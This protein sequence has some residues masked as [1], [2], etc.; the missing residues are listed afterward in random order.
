MDFR[1]DQV[2][3]RF[4][5]VS[6]A[7]LQA[8]PLGAVDHLYAELGDDLTTETR[9]QMQTWWEASASDRKAT[10]QQPERFGLD[11]AAVR[12]QFAFYHE[13]FVATPGQ[14]TGPAT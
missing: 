6:F 3:D 4:F 14:G 11:L 10:P 9:H 2:A 5:D 7:A 13:R 12:Q 1:E 8:D